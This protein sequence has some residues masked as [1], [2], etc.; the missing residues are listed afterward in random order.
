ML[1]QGDSRFIQRGIRNTADILPRWNDMH[2]ADI[3]PNQT[4]MRST[5]DIPELGETA[6]L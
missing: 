1:N 3:T 2:D 6:G 5:A 4:Y